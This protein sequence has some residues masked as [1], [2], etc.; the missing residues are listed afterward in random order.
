[1]PVCE[2][3]NC[4]SQFLN[5]NSLLSKWFIRFGHSSQC[6]I[7]ARVCIG[8][9][10]RHRRTGPHFSWAILLILARKAQVMATAW[11]AW[12]IKIRMRSLEGQSV[13]RY[14]LLL[15]CFLSRHLLSIQGQSFKILVIRVLCACRHAPSN[16]VGPNTP[17]ISADARF[18]IWAAS[19][20]ASSYT[21]ISADRYPGI[22][23]LVM[24]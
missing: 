3:V 18:E 4:N 13:R 12:H 11:W 2:S 7:G 10:V 9:L 15:P 5:Y 22:S 8:V 1:M 6:H 21:R 19:R 14:S 24:L 17:G 16:C 20:L 23:M